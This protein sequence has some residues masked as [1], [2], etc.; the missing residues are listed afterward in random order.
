MDS[1]DEALSPLS[2]KQKNLE[3]QLKEVKLAKARR[4][5]AEADGSAPVRGGHDLPPPTPHRALQVGMG[6]ANK[7]EAQ[8]LVNFSDV[9]PCQHTGC[10][11]VSIILTCF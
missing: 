6:V 4:L 9:N 1:S 5:V 10:V 3:E 7:M 11:A 2:R 8:K